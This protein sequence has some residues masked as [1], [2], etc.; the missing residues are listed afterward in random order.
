MKE[1]KSTDD[2]GI[3]AE[4]LKALGERDVQNLRMLLNE[5]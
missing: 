2:S 1:N 5:V 3:I 4:C